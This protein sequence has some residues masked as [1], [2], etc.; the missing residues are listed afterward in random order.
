[1]SGRLQASQGGSQV[2]PIAQ[3]VTKVHLILHHRH[4]SLSCTCWPPSSTPC[5]Q[6][7][8]MPRDRASARDRIRGRV[9]AAT[10][11]SLRRLIRCYPYS[12]PP[13][14]SR[15]SSHFAKL[16]YA[17]YY[18]VFGST[19]LRRLDDAVPRRRMDVA[20][21]S[22][23]PRGR[24]HFCRGVL[25]AE[26]FNHLV[27]A[28]EHCRRHVEAERLGDLAV[29]HRLV[30]GTAST[31]SFVGPKMPDRLRWSQRDTTHFDRL[32]NGF[33]TSQIVNRTHDVLPASH[34]RCDQIG[35]YNSPIRTPPRYLF[36]CNL[37]SSRWRSGLRPRRRGCR[38]RPHRRSYIL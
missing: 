27:G 22:N 25:A 16:A 29:E 19:Y 14:M 31:N 38:R 30:P 34:R 21:G 13:L 33:A 3:I 32:M 35:G 18:C 15:R 1:V 5:A 23:C 9:A 37:S 2:Y 12:R 4:N 17:H 20:Y 6:A 28:R 8:P 26:S 11:P 7:S 10:H 36:P 24:L